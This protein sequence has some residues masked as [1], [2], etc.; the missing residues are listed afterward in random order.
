MFPFVFAALPALSGLKSC[1][2]YLNCIPLIVSMQK[3]QCE[4]RKLHQ[5][6]QVMS[7]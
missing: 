2:I 6:S 7:L 3:K 4:N 5:L 1:P